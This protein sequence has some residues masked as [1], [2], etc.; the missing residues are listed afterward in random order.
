MKKRKEKERGG[1]RIMAVALSQW[2]SC[3]CTH[4]HTYTHS[5][6]LV[7]KCR[8]SREGGCISKEDSTAMQLYLLCLHGVRKQIQLKKKK[9]RPLFRSLISVSILSM[10]EN[11]SETF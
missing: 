4:A 2:H 9:Q 8:L 5:R 11:L 6:A 10:L 3:A 7:D 1:S